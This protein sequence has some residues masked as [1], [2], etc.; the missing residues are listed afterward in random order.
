MYTYIYAHIVT[1][2][3]GIPDTSHESKIIIGVTYQ[4]SNNV[5]QNRG[6]SFMLPLIPKLMSAYYDIIRYV[7]SL[8]QTTKQEIQMHYYCTL[9]P[10]PSSCMGEE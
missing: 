4:L 9:I 6:I 7:L 5:S 3:L 1:D 8:F 2:V 10:P